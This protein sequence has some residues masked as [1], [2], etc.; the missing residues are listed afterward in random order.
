MPYP[1]AWRP[2]RPSSTGAIAVPGPWS[3]PTRPRRGPRFNP[4]RNFPGLL[5]AGLILDAYWSGVRPGAEDEAGDITRPFPDLSTW[6]LTCGP[7][8]HPGPPYEFGVFWQA[9][10]SEAVACNVPIGNQAGADH[11]PVPAGSRTLYFYYG[12]RTTNPDRHYAYLQ[13]GRPIIAAEEPLKVRQLLPPIVINVP[14]VTTPAPPLAVPTTRPLPVSLTP[15][16]VSV[17]ALPEGPHRGYFPLAP[18]G[19]VTGDRPYTDPVVRFIPLGVDAPSIEDDPERKTPVN[20]RAGQALT[21]AFGLLSLYGTSQA[22]INA[23]WLALPS[24]MRTRHAR[25]SDKL[26]DLGEHWADISLGD[27]FA[28]SLLAGVRV[29]L[30]GVLYGK[31]QSAL[32]EGFGEAAGFGLYRAWATGE[33]AYS[34]STGVDARRLNR[35]GGSVSSNEPFGVLDVIEYQS[36][37]AGFTRGRLRATARR[38][39]RRRQRD[40]RERLRHWSPRLHKSRLRYLRNRRN[41]R[42]RRARSARRNVAWQMARGGF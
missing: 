15:L 35:G 30:A 28:N 11:L 21:A 4:G 12:P 20:S 22:F 29:G 31:A 18:I 16:A 38:R 5:L 23:L 14:G 41:M 27:A 8:E 25:N 39:H 32:S 34:G 10:G 2:G 1:V 36:G 24:S 17:P 3:I 7:F 33:F 19:T 26:R 42:R 9:F 37:Y 6:Q 13:Y 40:L